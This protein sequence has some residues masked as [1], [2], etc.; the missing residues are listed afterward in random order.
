MPNHQQKVARI[1]VSQLSLHLNGRQLQSDWRASVWTFTHLTITS[2]PN[3]VKTSRCEMT[4]KCL[5]S[6]S[7]DGL[8]R[9]SSLWSVLACRL[10][11]KR[12]TV[13][14]QDLHA[15]LHSVTEVYSLSARVSDHFQQKRRRRN[16]QQLATSL[17]A[18]AAQLQKLDDIAK[19]KC[20]GALHLS[21]C[22][23]EAQRRVILIRC[24]AP[25]ARHANAACSTY[26]M[27]CSE[28]DIL[29]VGKM[30]V[31]F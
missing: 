16:S 7:F 8:P 11:H 4:S 26:M 29:R 18:D 22:C 12:H 19:L 6:L 20:F 9:W 1:S 15:E 17:H 30:A 25:P 3:A 23:K 2:W 31:P 24:A 21:C 10:V 5:W 28:A 27:A 13:C 14:R